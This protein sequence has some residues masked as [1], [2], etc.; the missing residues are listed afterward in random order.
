M[1]GL[2]FSLASSPTNLKTREPRPLGSYA[3][4]N[5][6]QVEF[7]KDSLSGVFIGLGIITYFIFT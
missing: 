7:P 1:L 5:E 2:M 4:W 3:N 6:A